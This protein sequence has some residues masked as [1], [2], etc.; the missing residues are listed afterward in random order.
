MNI[1]T[2]KVL[3]IKAFLAYTNFYTTKELDSALRKLYIKYGKTLKMKEQE[4]IATEY[5]NLQGITRSEPKSL[6]K[7]LYE[8]G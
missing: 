4:R 8:Y 5:D 2:N 3:K 7:Y 1:E 6:E